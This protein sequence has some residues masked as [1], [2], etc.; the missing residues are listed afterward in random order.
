MFDLVVIF[1][2]ISY[3]QGK[4]H[5]GFGGANLPEGEEMPEVELPADFIAMREASRARYKNRESETLTEED[6]CP[7]LEDCG[8][9]EPG[10]DAA[11]SAVTQVDSSAVTNSSVHSDGLLVEDEI[12]D[13]LL[14]T[15]VHDVQASLSSFSINQ[16]PP[17]T[18][19]DPLL[20]AE[21]S[22]G[23]PM[24]AK[25]AD[26]IAGLKA[27][28]TN[29]IKQ[30]SCSADKMSIVDRAI[31]QPVPEPESP[32]DAPRNPRDRRKRI[33]SGCFRYVARSDTPNSIASLVSELKLIFTE[34]AIGLKLCQI[35]TALEGHP[36]QPLSDTWSGVCI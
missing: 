11:D 7:A 33:R 25:R 17:N 30:G 10:S 12:I 18:V 1:N 3:F 34:D 36:D 27:A 19:E 2:S 35:F 5:Y 31:R 28:I 4:I 24:S 15:T 32:P 21:A 16:N 22:S 20:A 29:A 8:P 26:E 9:S 6:D 13:R 23:P 14:E